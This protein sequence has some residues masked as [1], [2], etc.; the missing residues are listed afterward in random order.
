MCALLT[1]SSFAPLLT[2]LLAAGGSPRFDAFVSWFAFNVIRVLPSEANKPVLAA[3]AER[4]AN[5]PASQILSTAVSSRSIGFLLAASNYHSAA[6]CGPLQKILIEAVES[7][8]WRKDS[9][10]GLTPEERELKWWGSLG[11]VRS[12]VNECLLFCFR[13]V[14][15]GFIN[16]STT[17]LQDSILRF[18]ALLLKQ[19]YVVGWLVYSDHFLPFMQAISRHLV[20]EAKKALITGI[21]DQFVSCLHFVGENDKAWGSVLVK[22]EKMK[23]LVEKT[24]DKCA[25]DEIVIP[26]AVSAPETLDFS[27]EEKVSKKELVFFAS[28]DLV[29]AVTSMSF[30]R[31]LFSFKRYSMLLSL[32]QALC[33]SFSMG[34]AILNGLKIYV[35]RDTVS[36]SQSIMFLFSAVHA[37]KKN[38]EE[39]KEYCLYLLKGPQSIWAAVMSSCGDKQFL[40]V[41]V[42]EGGD[43]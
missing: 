25:V 2:Q 26:E 37:M 22:D 28:N 42:G 13:A 34:K 41:K 21:W 36:I 8:G 5:V 38:E 1:S 43:A 18:I 12:R 30:L 7:E 39:E 4:A 24:A 15:P 23:L 9:G 3:F 19:R 27:S 14:L 20:G 11:R 40:G 6:V 16:Y 35:V 33:V 10:V 31:D 32:Y 17:F 29:H